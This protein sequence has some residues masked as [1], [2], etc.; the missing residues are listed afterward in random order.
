[1]TP[2]FCAAVADLATATNDSGFPSKDPNP[3][4]ATIQN[5]PLT[6]G[7]PAGSTGG[8]PTEGV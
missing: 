7:D 3:A 2:W 4:T 6:V 8:P 1:L 5:R